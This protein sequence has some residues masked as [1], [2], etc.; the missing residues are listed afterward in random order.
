[1]AF[2]FHMWTTCYFHL[3][4][5]FMISWFFL[6]L[7]IIL[8]I[9]VSLLHWFLL[10]LMLFNVFG[11]A[12]CGC[13]FVLKL[14]KKGTESDCYIKLIFVFWLSMV[15]ETSGWQEHS[16][17]NKQS[18]TMLDRWS[19]P[20]RSQFIFNPLSFRSLGL[21]DAGQRTYCDLS[22]L[23]HKWVF[24]LH[25]SIY[26]RYLVVWYITNNQFTLHKW[27][28]LCDPLHTKWWFGSK[29]GVSSYNWHDFCVIF[30]GIHRSNRRWSPWVFCPRN[31]WQLGPAERWR[32]KS[33][34]SNSWG[35]PTEKNI[36]GIP[37]WK[38]EGDLMVTIAWEGEHLWP[39]TL[40]TTLKVNDVTKERKKSPLRWL[41]CREV[42]RS[43][44][45]QWSMNQVAEI[46]VI[47]T[48]F[49]INVAVMETCSWDVSGM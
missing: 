2:L 15:I 29:G 5:V 3:C 6:E 49:R 18:T 4:W 14:M 34:L 13:Y 32:D 11:L 8:D 7:H 31:S 23:H 36:R 22:Q 19:V 43:S 39:N 1:M 24:T 33:C 26:H 21:P 38:L 46:H 41:V 10:F 44:R 42:S 20:L 12:L 17:L 35:S 16:T 45:K 25:T 30:G 40:N 27:Y 47:H 48:H 37:V 9:C 28:L